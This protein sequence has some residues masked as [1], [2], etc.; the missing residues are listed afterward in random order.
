M[1]DI[2]W[3]TE[4]IAVSGAFPNEDIPNL[5]NR[6]IDAILD[7]RSEYSDDQ[8]LI[9]ELGLEFLRIEIDDRYNPTF[10]QLKK[11]SNFVEPLLDKGKKILIHCQNG[12]GRSPLVAISVL[13]KRGMNVADAVRLV[14]DKHPGVSFSTQQE[15]FIYTQLNKFLRSVSL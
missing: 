6:G 14:E 15:K 1:A 10:E 3:I 7:V 11:I 12:Y 9:N 2:S 5:K 8:K 13:A 4:Q